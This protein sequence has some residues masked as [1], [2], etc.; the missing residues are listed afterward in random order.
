MLTVWG[1]SYIPRIGADRYRGYDCFGSC[2]DHRHCARCF[3][4]YQE[5]AVIG[6]DGE[7]RWAGT[8]DGNARNLG[9]RHSIDYQHLVGHGHNGM[10][11]IVGNSYVHGAGPTAMK[12]VT[13][14]RV[15]D[16]L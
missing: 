8:D 10:T 13:V 5:M 4:G 3:V 9:C 12:S 15:A 11:P 14:S 7:A 1:K 16:T 2:V 6:C